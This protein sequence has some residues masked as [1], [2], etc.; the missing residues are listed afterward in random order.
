[1]NEN[2][3][4]LTAKNISFCYPGQSEPTVFNINLTLRRGEA[5]G[6]LGPNGCG[7]STLIDIL[8]G[9]KKPQKGNLQR[10]GCPA[11]S[12]ALVPQDYAFYPQLTCLENL[13]FF[14]E[15][16]SI[17]KH[18][19]D[20][21][22]AQAIKDCLLEPF[23]EKRAQ[24]CSGGIRRKLNLAIAL[25][26]RPDILLLDEPTV[27]VDLQSRALLL[28]L[29]KKCLLD[30]CAVL[31]ATHYMEE[32]SAVCNNI[33]LMN[34]GSVIT[35][36]SL[37]TLLTSNDGHAPFQDLDALFIHYTDRSLRD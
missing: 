9:L 20:N 10:I 28:A 3:P 24:Q 35:S 5:T 37:S 17:P 31:Y 7:K 36:G 2:R 4:V 6:L 18:D 15:I 33:V 16:L 19:I 25:L 29:V 11:P 1:M 22:I 13:R 21:R 30:G 32:V 26:Q 34:Q 14:G 23:L 8:T 12:L 27:G